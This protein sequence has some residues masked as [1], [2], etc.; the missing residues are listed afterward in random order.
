V[1]GV[2]DDYLACSPKCV[3]EELFYLLLRSQIEELLEVEKLV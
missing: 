1:K 3:E 2:I